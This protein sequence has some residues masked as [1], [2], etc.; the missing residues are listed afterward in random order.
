MDYF[1]CHYFAQM[2]P[3]LASGIPFRLI[4]VSFVTCF[5]HFL[6]AFLFPAQGVLGSSCPS[7][8]QSGC[9][10]FAREWCLGPRTGVLI[11]RGVNTVI[12][13]G[14]FSV[15]RAGKFMYTSLDA[16][17]SQPAPEVSF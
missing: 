1:Y 15:Y 7:L 11:L 16:S 6:S 2:F 3:D 12:A 9:Q 8:P 10:A 14:S 4:F 17:D 5:C 13:Y